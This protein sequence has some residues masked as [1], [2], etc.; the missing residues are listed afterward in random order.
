MRIFQLNQFLGETLWGEKPV[1]SEKSAGAAF[2]QFYAEEN[3]ASGGHHP[4]SHARDMSLPAEPNAWWPGETGD[5]PL[6]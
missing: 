3:G 2:E 1:F 4:M 5:D 6:R